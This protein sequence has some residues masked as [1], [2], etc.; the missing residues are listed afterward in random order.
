[1][2]CLTTENTITP[3]QSFFF[4]PVKLNTFSSHFLQLT[5]QAGCKSRYSHWLL[6]HANEHLSKHKMNT[7]KL[8]FLKGVYNQLNIIMSLMLKANNRFVTACNKYTASEARRS[9]HSLRLNDSLSPSLLSEQ[10]RM[11]FGSLTTT[12]VYVLPN[13]QCSSCPHQG[14]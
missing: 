14:T 8:T 10:L 6:L 12:S 7:I 2:K 5:H 1:M 4:L 9:I 13:S 11:L 3:L